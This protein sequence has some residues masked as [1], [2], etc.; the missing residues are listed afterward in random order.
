M[1]RQYIHVLSFSNICDYH[2]VDKH[3]SSNGPYACVFGFETPRWDGPSLVF[4][5]E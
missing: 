2:V 1:S 5:I 4:K 3:S